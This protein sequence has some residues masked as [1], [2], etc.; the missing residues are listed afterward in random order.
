MYQTIPSAL[1][2]SI[3]IAAIALLAACELGSTAALGGTDDTHTGIVD[4]QGRVL[5]RDARPFGNV[6]VRLRGQNLIDTTDSE[7]RYQFLSTTAPVPAPSPG[8]VDTVDYLRDGQ[9]VVSLPVPS[10]I[11]T[12]PD[13]MLVQ[14]DLSG[15]VVGDASR[16]SRASCRIRLPN[17]TSQ[18]VDLEW[19]AV[20][21][22]FGGFAY[23]RYQ[24][25]V[26]SFA[27][28]AEV[29][30]DSDRVLG[31]SDSVHF[32]SRAGDVSFP[33]FGSVNALPK[34][35]IR[36]Y[37]YDRS[38]WRYGNCAYQETDSAR[39]GRRQ[40]IH[41]YA[42]VE[43]NLERLEAL[44]WN[45]DGE[46]WLRSSQDPTIK[47]GPADAPLS[48]GPVYDT[49][50]TIPGD[51]APG[52]IWYIRARALT[53]DGSWTEDTLPVRIVRTP[54]YA[55]IVV[56]PNRMIPSEVVITPGSRQPVYLSDSGLAGAQIVSRKLY[57]V[58]LKY[59]DTTKV[60][61]DKPVIL[62]LFTQTIEVVSS[63]CEP[64]RP[65]V[66]GGLLVSGE[67]N[68]LAVSGNDT[69]ITFPYPFGEYQLRYEVID[70]DGDT[71][72]A[73][74]SSAIVSSVA[75]RIDSIVLSA[76]SIRLD[77]SAPIPS[78]ATLAE[79][80]ST[81]WILTARWLCS[82]RTDS[83]R[84]E[85]SDT[86]RS[87]V[88]HPPT[89]LISTK[90]SLLRRSAEIDGFRTDTTFTAPSPLR[91]TFS[92][93]IQDPSRIQGRIF[94]RGGARALM[95]GSV[96]EVL[97]GE[98]ARLAWFREDST[99]HDAVA[100][101]FALP[102]R[103]GA[104]RLE[105]DIAVPVANPC[106]IML[107]SSLDKYG[108]NT[109]GQKPSL[110]WNIP[111]GFVGRLSLALDSARWHDPSSPAD[112]MGLDKSAVLDDI[113]GIALRI[114]ANDGSPLPAGRMELDNIVWR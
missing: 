47:F 61:T 106:R 102:A 17:G 77:W 87:I 66:G 21:R 6:V 20:Q 100:V 16:I 8:A 99:D 78:V 19:N 58:Q 35:G 103:P 110:G 84:M 109:L 95:T 67:W 68:G 70:S 114:D 38:C 74:A 69:A 91:M 11:A 51:L 30:D 1:R 76:D 25:G 108:T 29:R 64:P 75:P 60:C 9:V 45:I 3:A 43:S 85:L 7:G 14:R 12:L 33:P 18:R 49:T 36:T 13:I 34:V 57:L 104:T 90:I 27:A 105:L 73:I 2:A 10:W 86:S 94:A 56:G 72:L 80:S 5:T 22:T 93:T 83:T 97:R 98:V 63:T 48:A 37:E 28:I 71:T 31:R 44:E 59:H 55:R 52:S 112:T 50:V 113:Q 42:E 39:V 101:A 65:I 88:L 46:H 40:S 53:T 54:P 41:L 79:L 32:T 81:R 96:G 23:F 26:D 92:G 111:A 62:N 82:D 89:D 24:G 107:L 4:I 15:I